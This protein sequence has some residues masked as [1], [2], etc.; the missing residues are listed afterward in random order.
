MKKQ[1][2]T[3]V[4]CVFLRK[5]RKLFIAKRSE[6]SKFL[7]R[8]YELIG[9]HIEFGESIE[10]GLKREVW[11]E[12]HIDIEIENPFYVFTYVSE[13]NT[14]HSVEICYFAKMLNSNQPIKLSPREHSEYR[15]IRKDEVDKYFPS[16]DPEKLAVKKGF[17]ILAGRNQ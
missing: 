8:K 9:G 17:N 15:W 12:L 6:S 16:D 1:Y 5:G 3:I 11:E 13:S 14:K 7:P 4:A 10:E 2:Q